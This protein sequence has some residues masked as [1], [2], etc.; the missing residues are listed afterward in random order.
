[1][2]GRTILHYR[3]SEQLGQGGMGVVYKAEDTKLDRLVALKFLPA[4]FGDDMDAKQR[5]VQEAKAASSLDHANIC[6]IYDIGE[7]QPET[8]GTQIFIVMAFYEGQTLKYRLEKGRLPIE[9]CLSFASQLADGLERAHEAGIVHRDIKPA[10]I[11]VTDRGEVKILDFGVAKLAGGL[12]LTKTGSTLGTAAYMSPEQARSESV[13]YRTDIWSLGVILYEMLA[14]ERPFTGTYDAATA[15]AIL[16]EEPKPLEQIREEVPPELVGIVSELLRKDPDDRPQSAAAVAT[17]LRALQGATGVVAPAASFTSK[18]TTAGKPNDF[19]GWRKKLSWAASVVGVL[20]LI[21]IAFLWI[22]NRG[23]RATD[24]SHTE[25][26][27][28]I[29]VIAFTD[30]SPGRDSEYIGDGIAEELIYG[31][32]KIDG[33]RVA[34]RTSSFYFKGRNDDIASIA[35]RLNVELILGG[36]VRRD[37]EALRITAELINANDG[38]Q[39]W[40]ERYDRRMEDVLAVQEDIT[41][42]IVGALKIRLS[43]TDSKAVDRGTSDPEAYRLYLLGRQQ[44][45]LRTDAGLSR[46]IELFQEAIERDPEF[47]RAYAGLADAYVIAADWGYIPAEKVYDQALEAARRSVSL[48]EDLAEGHVT[49][50]W[51]LGLYD[52]KWEE[53]EAAF[54]RAIDLQPDYATAHQ[55]YG[56]MLAGLGRFA[57]ATSHMKRALELDPLSPIINANQAMPYFCAR[58]VEKAAD[59]ARRAA[60]LFPDFKWNQA[61]LGYTSVAMNELSDSERHFSQCLPLVD[62]VAGIGLV[63]GLMGKE[64][65]ARQ[66]LAE[67]E[68]FAGSSYYQVGKAWIHLGLGERDDAIRLFR[69]GVSR[70]SS[71]YLWHNSPLYDSLRGD[72]RFDELLREMRLRK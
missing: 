12:D 34:A 38:F 17:R 33:L 10:N 32:G 44:W 49:L 62:C 67:M 29:A 46:S 39:L 26:T 43:G 59:E 22:R 37:G 53:A 7:F 18:G 71:I 21:G 2:T 27:P 68:Q 52:H 41:Q 35:D 50:G 9:E 14:G 65:E 69:E 24:I 54:E 60:D 48:D 72:P 57:E 25:A 42:S 8:G 51:L 70:G 31:L 20:V 47:A 4:Q 19:A 36:S 56:E 1:M 3:I 64:A 13:G 11:M 28:S 16:N 58:D 6:T 61:I 15:Y 5:F 45:N 30:L 23:D 63:H 40:S 66:M 55:W